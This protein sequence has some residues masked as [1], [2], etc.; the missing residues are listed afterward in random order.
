VDE[1]E[2]AHLIEKLDQ[3][4]GAPLP[5]PGGDAELVELPKPALERE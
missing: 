3:Y 4:S 2:R 5:V 1:R